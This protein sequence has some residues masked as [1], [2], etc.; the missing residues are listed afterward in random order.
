MKK[1]QLTLLGLLTSVLVFSQE[2]IDFNFKKD[3][4][5]ILKQTK[6]ST[7]DVFYELLFR[8]FENT[9]TTLSNYEMLALQIGYTNNENYWPYQDIVLEREIWKLNE[10][11]KF[12]EA[13]EKLDLLLSKNP[14]SILGNREMSYVYG[15]L[16]DKAKQDKYFQRFDLVVSSVLSTGDGTSYESSWFTLSPADGQW[17]IRLA[18]RQNICLMASGRDKHGNFHDILGMKG[19]NSDLCTKLYF[20]IQPASKRMFGPE[21]LT[22]AKGNRKKD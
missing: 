19:N 4:E 5:L 18:F 8:R 6:D 11:E 16:G 20:N 22:P 21:G 10:E 12:R 15:K 13:K 9:D 7:S 1:L 3:Y 2:R 17:I 14:F